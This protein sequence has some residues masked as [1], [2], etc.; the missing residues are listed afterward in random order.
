MP[1]IKRL[2]YFDKQ[3][4]KEPDFTDEQQYHLEMRR[5]HN[6]VMHTPGIA[7]GLEVQKT[8]GRSV[9]VSPGV[10]IDGNGQEMVLLDP[11][12]LNL[13][14]PATISPPPGANA[15]IYITIAYAEAPTNPQPVEN[16]LGQTRTSER[17]ALKVQIVP[18]ADTSVIILATFKLDG[19]GSIPGSVGNKF[20]N[21]S[22]PMPSS[23]NGVRVLAGA[24]LTDNS[25]SIRQLK[26]QLVA[27]NAKITLGAGAS[28][29][30]TAFNTSLNTASNPSAFLLVYAYSTTLNA[31]FSWTQE[32]STNGTPGN[33]TT[34]QTVAFRNL[35]TSPIEI[36]YSIYAVLEN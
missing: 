36:T 6:K 19:A 1:E 11:I 2:R 17:P 8:A 22:L 34:T 10:A 23:V 7:D 15:D 32:Y 20:D 16:P 12:G 27:L 25:V 31:R 26:K 35:I 14:T 13:D 28:Q 24:D 29:S 3:Y 21:G 18:P 9:T 30:V 4:L 33:L 5:R